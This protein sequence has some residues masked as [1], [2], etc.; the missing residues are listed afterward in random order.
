MRR[1]GNTRNEHLYLY[2]REHETEAYRTSSFKLQVQ[3]QNHEANCRLSRQQ[4]PASFTFMPSISL[5]HVEEATHRTH[6]PLD[7]DKRII[8][9]Q[10]VAK[11]SAK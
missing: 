11:S 4:H 7:F 2:L 10:Q 3:V 6:L 1:I 8:Y 5:A 9:L